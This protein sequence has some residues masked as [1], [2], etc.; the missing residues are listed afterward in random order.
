MNPRNPMLFSRTLIFFFVSFVFC[1]VSCANWGA[2]ASAEEYFSIGMA[3]FDM[4]KYAEAEKW[5]NRA[6]SVDKTKTASE[7]NL[8]RIAFETK[9]YQEALQYFERILD[10]DP[11]NVMTLK[12][13]AYTSI[14][15]GNIEGA[16]ALYEKILA[17]E[18]ENADDGYNYALVLYTMEKYERSEAVLSKYPAALL[19]NNEV[20]LLFARIQRAQHKPEAADRYAQWLET[21]SDP[22]VRYEYALLLE[23]NGFYVRALEECRTVLKD[24][25]QDSKEPKKSTLHYTIARLLLIADPENEEGITELQ[26]AITEGFDDKEALETLL[27]QKEISAAHKEEIQRIIDDMA[28]AEQGK[29]A[30]QD[31]ASSPPDGKTDQ[32]KT[33]E[34]SA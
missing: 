31:E 5:L 13:A 3:Y 21:N 7:Y 27:T 2:V 1:G 22:L 30:P 4:G 28:T 33:S 34:T 16:E 15:L 9:R 6:K 20:I 26:S 11:Y 24:L 17:L 12:A 19:E 18:P 23:E 25:P 14:K 32:P 8:G 10:K 29:E